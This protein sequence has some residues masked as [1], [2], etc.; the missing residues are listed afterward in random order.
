MVL[1]GICVFMKFVELHVIFGSFMW[2]CLILIDDSFNYLKRSIQKSLFYK[3][4]G[5]FEGGF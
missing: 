5:N 3:T 1:N 2:S 4:K